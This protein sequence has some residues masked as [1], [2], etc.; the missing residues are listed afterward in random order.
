MKV[1]GAIP[2]SAGVENLYTLTA[3]ERSR[4]PISVRQG[5]R[6]LLPV[7]FCAASAGAQAAAVADAALDFQWSLSGGLTASSISFYSGATFQYDDAL[8]FDNKVREAQGV[9]TPYSGAA[10][11]TTTPSLS[12]SVTTAIS[13]ST[14]SYPESVTAQLTATA[15]AV[16]PD[17]AIYERAVASSYLSVG[18]IDPI[19]SPVDI[20]PQ[21]FALKTSLSQSSAYTPSPLVTSQ[22]ATSSVFASLWMAVGWTDGAGRDWNVVRSVSVNDVVDWAYDLNPYSSGFF[23]NTGEELFAAYQDPATSAWVSVE[24]TTWADYKDDLAQFALS[25][26]YTHAQLT[27]YLSS[28]ASEEGRAQAAPVPEPTTVALLGLGLLSLALR[29]R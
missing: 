3:G 22:S 23:F 5:L 8:P 13:A 27:M 20:S 6:K 9:W 16:K 28:Y 12:S 26:Y 14:G 2:C 11:S 10:L 19:L 4:R 25:S 21:A 7:A 1:A 29:R 17:N 15:T 18:R 24:E